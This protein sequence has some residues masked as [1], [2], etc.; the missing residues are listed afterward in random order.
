M[1]RVIQNLSKGYQQRVGIAQ[2]LLGSPPVLILDE[3]TEGLDPSAARRGA[4]AHQVPRRQ[5]HRHPLHA[6]PPRGDDDLREGAHH[7]PGARWSP[8]TRSGS[9]PQC[10]GQADETSRSKRS[11]SSSPPPPDAARPETTR[12]R[13]ALA[14]ARKELS[15]YFTTPWAY[16][17]FTAMVGHLLVLLRQPAGQLQGGAGDGPRYGWNRLPPESGP[18]A[19][20]PTASSCSSGA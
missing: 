6:H 2:A 9:W 16:A 1:D 10:T 12:M 18:T 17:V 11:S 7:Q 19:T 15:I 4:R 13:T 5:A 3:P 14:I 20:S 8:S